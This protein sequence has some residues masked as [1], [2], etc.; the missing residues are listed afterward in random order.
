MD[1]TGKVLPAPSTAGNG[2]CGGRYRQMVFGLL[3]GRDD[4]ALKMWYNDRNARL[5]FGS[6][7]VKALQ[8]DCLRI[9]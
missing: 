3:S 5:F 2:A 1:I 9:G 4:C 8:Q 7:G 6:I